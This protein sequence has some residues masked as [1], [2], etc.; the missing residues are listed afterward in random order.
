MADDRVPPCPR[1]AVGGNQD[2]R[3]DF[4]MLRWILRDVVRR[5]DFAYPS[6][7]AQQKAANLILFSLR[8]SDNA[9]QQEP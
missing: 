9:P 7:L 6:G 4:K 2:H 8:H 5:P 3:V 1:L